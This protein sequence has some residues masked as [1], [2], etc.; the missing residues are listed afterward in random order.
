M[1]S[2]KNEQ[3]EYATFTDA[4][5]KVLTAP[6]PELTTKLN[7]EKRAR[8]LRSKKPP[9]RAKGQLLGYCP[10]LPVTSANVNR[11]PQSAIRLAETDPHHSSGYLWWR[12]YCSAESVRRD[13][14]TD[15]TVRR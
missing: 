3:S 14:G 8:K 12:G 10:T 1:P 11:F 6:R 13:T 5:K 9:S 7:A 4:L 15:G 2:A